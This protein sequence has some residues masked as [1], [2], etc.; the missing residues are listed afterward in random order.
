MLSVEGLV[1]LE[2][3]TLT[4]EVSSDK[5]LMVLGV[6]YIVEVSRIM[7]EVM[8]GLEIV[9]VVYLVNTVGSFGR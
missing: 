9:F 3:V 1:G 6:G 5:I 4:S 2:G 8:V 7:E